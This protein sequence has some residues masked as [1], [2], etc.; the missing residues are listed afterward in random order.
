MKKS[1]VSPAKIENSE[2]E[3]L[4]ED[5]PEFVAYLAFALELSKMEEE[6]N[7]RT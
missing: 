1:R 4:S 6:E 2:E 3:L 7:T 5:D